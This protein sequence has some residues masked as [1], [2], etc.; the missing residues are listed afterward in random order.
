[1]G[2]WAADALGNDTA[3]DWAEDFF[4]QPSPD[5]IELAINAVLNAQDYLDSDVACEAL[6][7]VE[8]VA[9]LKAGAETKNPY[10]GNINQLAGMAEFVPSDS[11]LCAAENA[12]E[13]I[14][15]DNSELQELWDEDGTNE[16]W[17]REMNSLL[18]RISS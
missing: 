4:S 11:L 9:G 8:I 12:L 17:H 1:M 16:E 14:L 15:G 10:S 6:A 7:A 2:A 13:R 3:C 5:A 18:A